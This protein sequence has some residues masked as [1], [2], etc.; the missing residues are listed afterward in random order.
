MILTSTRRILS[1]Y[2]MSLMRSSTVGNFVRKHLTGPTTSVT[3]DLT[4][5]QSTLLST[6]Q[7]LTTSEPATTLISTLVTTS[8]PETTRHSTMVTTS[9][10][11]TTQHSTTVTT[12]EPA[13]TQHSTTETTSEPTTTRHSTM[14]TTSEPATTR[15]STTATT[16]ELATTQH[17]TM[18][19]TSEPTTTQQST[20]E[21]TSEA[22]GIT[23]PLGNTTNNTELLSSFQASTTLG[24]T[25]QPTSPKQDI[26]EV[27]CKGPVHTSLNVATDKLPN[28]NTIATANAPTVPPNSSTQ[29]ASTESGATSPQPVTDETLLPRELQE[30]VASLPLQTKQALGYNVQ[31]LIL[32]CQF[33]GVTC[34]SW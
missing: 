30:R 33:A 6:S 19:T 16:S 17:S 24:I 3:T 9:E 27:V 29:L 21:T 1:L 4:T 20:M 12:S 7:A 25:S 13:T 14:V 22:A 10:P 8:E 34:S 2:I 26:C 31:Q 5:E 15:H 28:S 23:M 11:A 18:E 32:D